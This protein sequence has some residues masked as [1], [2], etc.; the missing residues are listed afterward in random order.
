[1]TNQS[2]ASTMKK[3]SKELCKNKWLSL[4]EIKAPELGING[5]VYS[6]ETRCNGEIV[7]LLPYRNPSNGVYEYLLKNEMTPCWSFEKTLS[8]IT[9]GWEGDDIRSDAVKELLEETGYKIEKTDLI[10]L[11]ASYAS[12]SAD[13]I[14][15]LF[16]VDLTGK[17]ESIPLG[18][19]SRIESESEAIW[20]K[21]N[22]LY[23]ILDPQVSV[24]YVRLKKYL[25]SK[26]R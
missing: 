10:N 19:G 21:P 25:V 17:E 15:S 11:G 12:K 6:H 13:T 23:E 2:T 3:G 24:M 4:M 14:Y 20:V 22:K 26:N 9:G 8:A 1:M 7:A 16:S 5:Y 18:D